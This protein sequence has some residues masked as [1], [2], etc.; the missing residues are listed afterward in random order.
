[1]AHRFVFL[2]LAAPIMSVCLFA[3][4][5]QLQMTPGNL[6]LAQQGNMYGEAFAATGGTTPYSWSISAGAM[7]PGIAMKTNGSFV[8]TPTA[9]GAFNF[10]AMVTDA[11]NKTA[12][13][14]FSVNVTPANGYDGP[15]QLPIATVASSMADTPAPGAVITVN[16][17]GNL[18]AALKSAQCGDTIELQAG[19]TFTGNFQFPALNCDSN[20]WII[21]RTSAPD[22]SLPAEGQRVTPCNAGVASLPGRPQYSCGN[23][24]NVLAK[25]VVSNAANGPVIFQSGAN[26]YRLLGLEI[27]RATG[28]K[29]SPTLITVKGTASYIVLDRGLGPRH[30]ARRDQEWFQPR[31]H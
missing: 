25:L 1:M 17:G 22:S 4:G 5:L 30:D 28:T 11:N 8:G 16:P 20:H 6:P 10:T 31:R 15:A 7:P 3:Q 9:V 14:N 19:A 24:Q 29:A 12:T 18:Q 26:H 23:P 27:T 2:V 21:V 13:G